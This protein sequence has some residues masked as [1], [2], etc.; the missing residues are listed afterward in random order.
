MSKT[1]S[2][3]EYDDLGVRFI[4]PNNWTVET[5]TW[6]KGTYGIT[7]DSPDGSFWALAIYPKGV[8]LDEAA[9]K[10]LNDLHAE[11]DEMETEEIERYVADN[12]LSGYEINFFYLDLTS[13]AQALKFEDEERG[14]VIFWQTCD[15][16]ALTGEEMSRVDVFEAMTHTL[17]SNL[18]GQEIEYW[19]DDDEFEFEKTEKEIR[20]EE[21]REYYRRRYEQARLDVEEKYWRAGGDERSPRAFEDFVYAKESGGGA[22]KR[23]REKLAELL[24]AQEEGPARNVVGCGDESLD[25]F[26]RPNDEDDPDAYYENEYA[27]R[28]DDSYDEDSDDYSDDYEDRDD[29]DE[30]YERR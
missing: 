21:E 28:E 12:V 1:S 8:D 11:Y 26:M 29:D 15:R 7:A 5:Q 19:H 4:Y 25:D 30:D 9:K 22:S 18:T 24:R 23:G 14:Y 13:T 17:V 20:A 27:R 6:D 2:F 3:K 16:L 10:I